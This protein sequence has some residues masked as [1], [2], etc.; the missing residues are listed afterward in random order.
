MPH[1]LHMHTLH[2]HWPSTIPTL[3]NLPISPY[4]CGSRGVLGALREHPRRDSSYSVWTYKPLEPT[5]CMPHTLHIHT[6]HIHWP[7][8]LPTLQ[9]LPISPYICGSRGVLGAR[10]SARGRDCSYSLWTYNPLVT[11]LCMPH[12]LH[13]HTTHIQLL[14]TLCNLP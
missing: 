6:L 5:L 9:N 8:T 13:I 7:S 3:Q 11:S 2:I 10:G 1:T 12:T 4:I 14:S